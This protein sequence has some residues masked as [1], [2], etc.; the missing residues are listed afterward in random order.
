MHRVE[1]IIDIHHE[2]DGAMELIDKVNDGGDFSV[3]MGVNIPYDQC[4]HCGN[5][6]KKQSEYC[7]HLKYELGRTRPDGTRIYAINGGYD[8][9][10]NKKAL[11]FFD[12]SYVFRPA[13][14]TGYMLKK[15][16][17]DMNTMEHTQGSAEA[18]TKLAETQEKSA[19]LRKM[20]E[21]TKYFQGQATALKDSSDSQLKVIN[22]NPE[23]FDNVVSQMQVLSPEHLDKL[24]KYPMGEILSTLADI[25]I[26]LT[27][28]EFIQ[29]VV[30]KKLGVTLP[31]DTMKQFAVDQAKVFEELA[32]NPEM[33]DALEEDL[34][35]LK[36]SSINNEIKDIV[37]DIR[38]SR[39]LSPEGFIKKAGTSFL[40]SAAGMR[41]GPSPWAD[42][43]GMLDVEVVTDPKDGRKY[44]A[45]M[46]AI[47]HANTTKLTGNIAKTVG[48]GALLAALFMAT[49]K[50][51]GIV[52]PAVGMG[53]LA[54]G[55]KMLYD[56]VKKDDGSGY[57]Y[58]DD[59]ELIPGATAMIE[60]RSSIE[61]TATPGFSLGTRAATTIAPM[62]GSHIGKKYYEDRLHTGTAGTFRTDAEKYMDNA[63]RIAYTHPVLTAGAGV[64]GGHIALNSGEAIAK[65]ARKLLGK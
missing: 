39:D 65:A 36:E 19:A 57:M 58:T 34:T 54:L 42:G 32:D 64:V 49:K 17:M 50:S 23:L 4:S 1:L 33:V 25:G 38:E 12:I 52:A 41:S 53:T 26:I 27:T 40:R 9:S 15:V 59:G 48:G 30:K 47:D 56:K 62:A 3:S 63:G 16:A 14:K 10:K 2:R 8:Y 7:D 13:D 61:K 44:Y 22:R 29:V 28:P 6:A 46:E 37:E 60:K 5:K 18:Y 45:S 24:S 51:K 21:I 11:N 43:R 55:A 31:L 35:M 20:S